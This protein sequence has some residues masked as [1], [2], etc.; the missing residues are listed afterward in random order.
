MIKILDRLFLLRM[1]Q[2]IKENDLISDFQFGFMAGKSFVDQLCGLMND[3]ESK[4]DKALFLLSVDS[5]GAYDRADNVTLYKRLKDN[6]L[7]SE[8]HPNVFNLLFCRTFKVTSQ[9]ESSS[10]WIPLRIGVPQG[11]PSAPILFKLYINAT[12]KELNSWSKG[13]YLDVDDNTICIQTR[14]NESRREFIHRTSS[15]ANSV[16]RTYR[17]IKGVIA[18]AKSVLILFSNNL[19]AQIFQESR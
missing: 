9:T 2:W 7:P 19:K 12:L 14:S 10:S 15:V 5:K 16:G 17:K 8:W 18:K 3:L 11:L 6:G 1:I 13:T 4:K